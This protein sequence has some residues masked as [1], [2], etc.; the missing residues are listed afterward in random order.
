MQLAEQI[1]NTINIWY[2][3]NR[4]ILPWR[5][6]SDPYKIWISEVILQQT[7][8]AQGISYYLKFITRFPD[9]RT[10]ASA[11][12]EEIL[13]AWQGMGYYTRARNLHKAA[14]I[15]LNSYKG[16]FPETP[17]KL[18]ELPG[19]GP[20]SSAAIA[21]MAFQYP[22]AAIDANT[23]RI[24]ARLYGI[25]RPLSQ[26]KTKKRIE[27]LAAD[28][29]DTEKPGE[30]NQAIMD[31][32]SLVCTPLNPD[33]SSCPLQKNCRAYSLGIT[34]KIPTNTPKRSLR[35]RYFHYLVLTD[36]T[37]ICLQKRKETD[38]WN[39]LYEFP[40]VE[41]PPG[42]YPTKDDWHRVT[43][44][45]NIFPQKISEK[46]R[47]ALSHQIIHATF[48]QAPPINNHQTVDTMLFIPVLSLKK[49]PMPQLIRRYLT[50]SGMIPLEKKNDDYFS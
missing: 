24:I 16:R 11:N 26:A 12:E 46:Y 40:L 49:Y 4:R 39:S 21:S 48:Y 42:K 38:I 19:I 34:E 14:R 41:L 32:G 43:G 20:Y 45:P 25:R 10:L 18:K 23:I 3:S 2:R 37:F 13:N 35:Q 36:G 22:V 15:L 47:H 17:E 5:D 31:F 33:C 7:R 9:L 44:I 29:L 30:F 50:D 6:T 28:L 1:R 27:K 8:V